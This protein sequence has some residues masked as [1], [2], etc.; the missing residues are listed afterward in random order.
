MKNK[1][2]LFWNAV[3]CSFEPAKSLKKSGLFCAVVMAVVALRF[4]L[5]WR[6]DPIGSYEFL[7]QCRAAC[8]SGVL[9]LG[10]TLWGSTLLQAYATTIHKK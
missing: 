9:C 2:H 6:S 1:L 3:N 10:L 5:C 4:L 7:Y 8:E